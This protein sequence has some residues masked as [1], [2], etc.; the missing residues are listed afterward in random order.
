[1]V[2]PSCGEVFDHSV[3]V[4]PKCGAILGTPTEDVAVP[5]DFHFIDDKEDD[6]IVRDR[7]KNQ[8]KEDSKPSSPEEKSNHK[9]V[10][11]P[12]F[13]KI[14]LVVAILLVIT[15]FVLLIKA[16]YDY[17]VLSFLSS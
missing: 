17:G 15:F 5:S 16:L 4:C 1:M 2:C 12:M 3:D 8:E 13:Q 7:P 14:E 6:S 10:R 9:N 11:S